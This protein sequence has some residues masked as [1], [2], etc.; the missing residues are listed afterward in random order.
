MWLL[1]LLTLSICEVKILHYVTNIFMFFFPIPPSQRK[2]SFLLCNI[3]VM[4]FKTQTDFYFTHLLSFKLMTKGKRNLW[5]ISWW[6]FKILEHMQILF[7][8]EV[9]LKETWYNSKTQTYILDPNWCIHRVDIFSFPINLIL[10]LF[11]LPKDVKRMS[12]LSFCKTTE[13]LF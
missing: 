13:N 1:L 6:P 10:V 7:R 5:S 4:I 2:Q 3:T 8:F 11:T 9:I 12:L